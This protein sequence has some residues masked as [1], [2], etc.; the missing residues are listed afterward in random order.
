MESN[1]KLRSNI[2]LKEEPNSIKELFAKDFPPV[3]WLV[4]GLIPLGGI[5]IL[6]GLP[7]A[8][9]T[10]LMLDI[11]I[12]ASQGKPLFGKFPTTQTNSLLLDEESGERLL[13]DRFKKLQ[14]SSE[15][16]LYYI[17]MGSSNF[18]EAYVKQLVV[19]CKQ[20]R[21]GLVM[22]DSLV[23]IHGGDENTS[24]D[25]A[26]VFRLLRML[27]SEGIT[28]LVIH[29]NT[30]ASANGEYGSQMRGSG[31]IQASVDC[32]LSLIRPYKDGSVTLEQVKNRY[33]KETP[34]IEISLVEHEGH[35]EFAY[36]GQLDEGGK[37][38][39][40]KPAIEQIV[41]AN[42][43][44]NQSNLHDSLKESGHTI[45]PKTLRKALR[46]MENELAISVVKGKANTNCYFIPTQESNDDSVRQKGH[47][48]YE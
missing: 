3:Q 34:T 29:H 47:P 39:S 6:H 26:K 21:I 17:T 42:P 27:T 10:W 30:K 5:T 35:I 8:G 13:F 18:N 2:K 25:S 16:P 33:A 19:W 9:K 24:K 45:S 41:G 4:D 23:R 31:D 11:A 37:L 43:G 22:V 12:K 14:A 1:E 44:I 7:M 38:A 20:N 46:F 32:Q 40:I 15:L 28:V 48:L 36:L